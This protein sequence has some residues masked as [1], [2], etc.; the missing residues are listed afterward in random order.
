M[1][2]KVPLQPYTTGKGGDGRQRGEVG[3]RPG[4]AVRGL[5]EGGK[6]DTDCSEQEQYE[7]SSHYFSFQED[8]G[9]AK[10]DYGRMLGNCY[11]R[12]PT[13]SGN[14]AIALFPVCI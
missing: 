6:A 5:C 4:I 3:R 10:Q 13:L 11:Q 1:Q 9:P 2:V 8:A 7:R 12:M 14:R